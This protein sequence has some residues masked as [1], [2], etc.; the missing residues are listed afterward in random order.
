MGVGV[1]P[2]YGPLSRIFIKTALTVADYRGF[3]DEQS[4]NRLKQ[5]GFERAND[6]VFPDLAFSLPPSVLPASSDHAGAKPRCWHRGHE[7]RRY[8]QREVRR[9]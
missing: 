1:G 2:I 7:V 5:Y 8:A 4:R 3:R 9:L 6:S